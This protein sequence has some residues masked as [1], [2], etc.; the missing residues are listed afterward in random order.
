M[1]LSNRFLAFSLVSALAAA[2]TLACS[3][4]TATPGDTGSGGDGGA[5]E[6]GGADAKGGSTSTGSAKGGSTSGGATSTGTGAA[7][8]TV[9]KAWE[10]KDGLESFKVLFGKQYDAADPTSEAKALTLGET[11]RAASKLEYVSTANEGYGKETGFINLT[12]PM[13]DTQVSF[14]E[15]DVGIELPVPQ[16]WTHA[17]VKCQLRLNAGLKVKTTGNFGGAKVYIKTTTDAWV[18]AS[19]AYAAF[20]DVGVWKEFTLEVDSPGFTDTTNT[21]GSFDPTT[22]LQFGIGISTPNEVDSVETPTSVDIDHCT[23]T[24]P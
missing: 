14:Q 21:K 17:I 10:F 16:D 4:G 5:G 13:A 23:V 19:G 7:T 12:S 20:D 24:T 8:G 3:E 1:K 15:I 2:S 18:Y 22:V 6:Q 9:I 11:L